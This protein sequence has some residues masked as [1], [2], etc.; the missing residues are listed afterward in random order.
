VEPIDDQEE[1]ALDHFPGTAFACG[2]GVGTQLPSDRT[3]K[4]DNTN[5]LKW[6]S[7][8]P[9]PL[10]AFEKPDEFYTPIMLPGM[11][12]PLDMWVAAQVSNGTNLYEARTPEFIQI[13][14]AFLSHE[15]VHW[16][17]LVG[18]VPML[19]RLIGSRCYGLLA[20]LAVNRDSFNPHLWATLCSQS[21]IIKKLYYATA[22]LHEVVANVP[23]FFKQKNDPYR[24]PYEEDLFQQSLARYKKRYGKKFTQVQGNFD[25]IISTLQEW[26]D[27]YPIQHVVMII[28][29]EY[30]LQ[31]A[32]DAKEI[33]DDLFTPLSLT[34]TELL[35]NLVVN[36]YFSLDR[37]G[38]NPSRFNT[39]PYTVYDIT[40]RLQELASVIQKAKPA[41]SKQSPENEHGQL[42]YIADAISQINEWLQSLPVFSW[43]RRRIV[44]GISDMQDFLKRYGFDLPLLEV[45]QSNF[46]PCIATVF[47]NKPTNKENEI[48]LHVFGSYRED[49]IGRIKDR[50][51]DND[52]IAFSVQANTPIAMWYT[53]AHTKDKQ[54]FLP[55][56]IMM[57]EGSSEANNLLV[58]L[59]NLIVFESLLEQVSIGDGIFCPL[60]HLCVLGDGCC[61]YA[62]LLWSIYEAGEK[63]MAVKELGWEPTRWIRPLCDNTGKVHV[64]EGNVT[65]DS[66]S[67]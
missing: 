42:E 3:Q 54:P 62:G 43:R 52:L 53:L 27:P 6:P 9:N 49:L 1:Q 16:H 37:Q 59:H 5:T 10:P 8:W 64:Q 26:F 38:R 22:P 23:H 40:E 24:N 30:I 19:M 67:R 47:K 58:P 31:G 33:S 63:A 36:E 14:D 41:R 18:V 15:L 7:D 65:R 28:L 4:D 66:I 46:S 50:L 44:N 56:V 20:L 29:A 25:N 13:I 34:P 11:Y 17:L 32:I 55:T 45:W 48:P 51:L 2:L 21:N 61:G 12:L 60:Y 39:Y 35:S 57:G